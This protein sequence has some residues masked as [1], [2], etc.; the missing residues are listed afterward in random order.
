[1]I[2]F[3]LK[4][5]IN[6][7]VYLQIANFKSRNQLQYSGRYNLFIYHFRISKLLILSNSTTSF[8]DNSTFESMWCQIFKIII[9]TDSFKFKFFLSK[10]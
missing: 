2:S 9:K 10:T 1:M 6:T 8:A 4:T 5:S 3:I 7:V